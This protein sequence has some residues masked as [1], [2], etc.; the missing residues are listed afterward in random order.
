MNYFFDLQGNGDTA[1]DDEGTD[2]P[3]LEAVRN[4]LQCSAREIV[5][6]AVKRGVTARDYEFQVRDESGERVLTFPF[7]MRLRYG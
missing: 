6:D 5:A 1:R 2:L 3:D 7:K 4:E